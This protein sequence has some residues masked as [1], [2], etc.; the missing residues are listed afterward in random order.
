MKD[1]WKFAELYRSWHKSVRDAAYDVLQSEPDANDAAQQVFIRLWES[2]D[3]EGIDHPDA[4]F[5]Q[6]GRNEAVTM[7]RRR[8]RRYSLRRTNLRL[9]EL[10]S[11]SPSPEARVLISER[12]EHLLQAIALLPPRCRLVCTLVFVEG[13]TH[14]ETAETLGVSIG[15]VE[16]QVSRGRRQL[17]E[18]AE[19]GQINLSQ[20]VDG[21]G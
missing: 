11:R 5:A 20:F 6:A 9:H 8:R 19:S 16:K 15:A 7:L 13:C 3:W 4:F 12:R 1:A 2:G 10:I 14:R 21:G 18:M 17:A